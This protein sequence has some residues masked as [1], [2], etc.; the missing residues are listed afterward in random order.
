MTPLDSDARRVF[1]FTIGTS[2][3]GSE[4]RAGRVFADAPDAREEAQALARAAFKDPGGRFKLGDELDDETRANAQEFFR[5]YA[6]HPILLSAEFATVRLEV[7][8]VEHGLVPEQDP[9]IPVRAGDAA[10]LLASDTAA[11]MF[12]AKLDD[13]ILQLLPRIRTEV[14]RLSRLSV[15]QEADFERAAAESLSKA[16]AAA[17]LEAAQRDA[18]LSLHLNGGYKATLPF[19]VHL[20]GH[21]PAKRVPAE[22]YMFHEDSTRPIRIPVHQTGVDA[23]LEE[24]LEAVEQ[25]TV[26]HGDWVGYAYRRTAHGGYE[27][28][29]LG[30]AIARLRTLS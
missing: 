27:A 18:V 20:V 17:W 8:G 3:L 10:Y 19:I 13:A 22:V 28:T 14:V 30:Q 23:R 25:G 15:T 12:C 11:G 16:L 6:R 24:D 4:G 5:R 2:L 7:E 9:R 21:M 1:V 26:R 29:F